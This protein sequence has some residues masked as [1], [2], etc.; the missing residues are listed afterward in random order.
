VSITL[1]PLIA[2]DVLVSYGAR[3][4]L[5]GVD[6]RASPGQRVGLVGENGSGKST[7]MRVLSGEQQPDGGTVRRP[8]DLVHLP[9]EPVFAPGTTVGA[10]LDQVLVPL[11]EAV[12]SVERLGAALARGG[13]A[14]PYVEALAWAEDHDA[15]DAD[16]RA[17]LAA[18]RLGVVLFDR[19]RKV[20]TLSG[21]ERSRVAMAAVLTRRPGCLLLDEP[22]NHLDDTAVDLVERMCIDLP[23]VV[24]VAS[25]DR[26]FLDRVCTHLVDLDPAALGTDGEG[27]NRSSGGFTA[28]LRVKA[29]ARARWQQAYKEQQDELARLRA[30]TQV[31]N[32]DVASGRG[33]RDNDKFVTKFKGA[34]VDRT[35][36]RRIHDAERRQQVAE[37]EAVPRPSD[38]LQMRATLTDSGGAVVVSGLR[39]THRLTLDAL[40]LGK[41]S[42]LLVS[43]ANGSGKSTLLH[44]LAGRVRPSSG[45]VTVTGRVGLLEQDTRF[46]DP[47]ATAREAYALAV[48]AGRAEEVSLRS[49]GLLPPASHDTAVGALST[50]QQRRLALAM[51]LANP[52]TCSCWTSRPTTCR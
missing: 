27:G 26:V 51:L 6:L 21:G 16:R 39:V 30:A 46:A 44:V 32:H 4:A 41:G 42:R 47:S 24:V 48:G 49:L 13:D 2:H 11:H 45:S 37:R 43:G 9:Q 25:H 33:P 12:R 22:T 3:T 14:Q 35:V 10:V 5:C 36:A 8:V 40:S 31:K 52:R 23:G 28:Y 17:D 50:G 19:A 1:Q 15:W 38:P 34:R 7:L 20:E 18:E 29:S